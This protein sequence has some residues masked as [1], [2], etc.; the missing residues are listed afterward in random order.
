MIAK[1]TCPGRPTDDYDQW[2]PLL[3]E[4]CDHLVAVDVLVVKALAL[5][6]LKQNLFKV[7]L[8]QKTTWR[9]CNHVA[10][11]ATYESTYNTKANCALLINCH[12]SIIVHKSN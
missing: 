3:E 8:Q 2:A 4:L 10:L 6:K 7:P 11:K 12:E 9:L 5:D 1:L